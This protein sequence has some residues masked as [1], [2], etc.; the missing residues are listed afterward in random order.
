MELMPAMDEFLHELFDA[1][2]AS[3]CQISL[4]TVPE[5]RARRFSS[6]PAAV[7]VAQTLATTQNVYFNVG[8][9]A[10]EPKGRGKAEDVSAIVALWA[11]VDFQSA[12]HANH[13]LPADA[14]DFERLIPEL[15]LPPSLIVDSGNGRHLYWLLRD[16]WLFAD[17]DD[18]S[19]GTLFA[20]GWHEMVCRAASR[21]GWSLENLGDITRVLRLPG[22]VNRKDSQSLKPVTIITADWSRRYSLDDFEPFLPVEQPQSV[23]IPQSADSSPQLSGLSLLPDSEPPGDKLVSAILESSVFRETWDH[24]RADLGD[25][26]AS[27]YDLSLA[28]IAMMRGWSDQEVARLIIAWRRRHRESPEKALRVDY[29][30]RTLQKARKATVTEDSAVDLSGFMMRPQANPEVST[31]PPDPGPMPESLC[32][33]PGFVSEVM[34]HCLETAPYPN[35]ALAFCGALALQALLAGRKVRDEADNRTNIYLLALAFSAGGKDWPRKL[36]T[37]IL[38]EVGM[39]GSLGDK[40]ASGEGIQDSLFLSP[41]LLFQTDEIDGIVQSIN[42][43]RDARYENILGTLLTMYSSAN[44]MYPMRRKAGKEAPGVIDQPCLVVY[45]T[46]VPT[47]YYNALSERMLTNGFFARMLI[48]EAGCRSNGQDAKIIKPSSRILETA[49]WWSE[50]APGTGNLQAWHPVP[51][52]VDATADARDLLRQS[53]IAAEVE[54]SEAEKRND[55]VGTTVWGRVHEQVRKL[56]L[57]YAISLDHVAPVIDHAAVEWATSFVTHQT[58]RMLFM[59][60]GHVAENPFHSECLK[61]IRKLQESPDQQLEHSVLLKRMKVDAR[62]FTELITTLEQQG[63]ICSIIRST[64]GRSHR[65]YQLMRKMETV[66]EGG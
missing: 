44:S 24:A 12:A 36:N 23:D 33:I 16:P 5:K 7:Q 11:D 60:H 42:K 38:H 55:A 53:R 58:K 17:K 56:S 61:L 3:G 54:Y 46:A 26:S 41:S 14:T 6:I 18:R 40:F 45:G 48:V 51:Q 59:A 19:R 15:P 30:S 21:L 27:A 47:H 22:T 65:V 13:S 25:Q 20:K 28:T 39:L 63:D 57:L 31:L 2:L 32:H 64:P 49:R 29:M 37:K 34:D 62:T 52:V 50:F 4:F 35:V 43:S 8:M 10:G 1:G 9:I 66:K